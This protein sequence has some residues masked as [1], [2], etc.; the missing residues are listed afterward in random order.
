MAKPSFSRILI[1]NDDGFDAHGIKLLERAVANLSDD[2]WVVAP[3][4]EQSAKGHALTLKGIPISIEEISDKHFSIDGTPTDCVLIALNKIL[5]KDRKP[6]LLLSGINRGGNLGDDMTYSGTVSAAME[7]ALSGIPSIALSQ[8]HESEIRWTHS[9]AYAGKVIEKLVEASWSDEIVMNVNFP[10]ASNK[11][12]GI[13]TARLGKARVI[14]VMTSTISSVNGKQS[15]IVT[16]E[17]IR[18]WD[19]IEKGTDVEAVYNGAISVTPLSLDM[20]HHKTMQELS[21][22]L[23][24]IEFGL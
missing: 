23:E 13:K 24:G 9:E 14:P 2:V 8:A 10:D 16:T 19:N 7:G 21:M 4:T 3:K 20:T 5:G 22:K 12:T 6:T 1:V 17:L 18:K 11:F 15:D